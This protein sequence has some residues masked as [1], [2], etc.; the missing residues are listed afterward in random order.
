MAKVTDR[1]LYSD[2]DFNFAKTATNDVARKFDS[3]D[4]KR[5]VIRS[6]RTAE[7]R[8]T[9][10]DILV[11]YN[12]ITSTLTVQIEYSFLDNND[13]IDITIERVK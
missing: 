7:P 9:L 1:F 5:D 2:L 11:D 10:R 8:I 6:L 13:T 3:N 12:N 4:I